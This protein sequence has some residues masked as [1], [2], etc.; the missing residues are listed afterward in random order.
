MYTVRPIEEKDNGA[1]EKVIRSCLIEY[2][3]NHEGTAWADPQLGMLS[4]AYNEEGTCY[5]VV[6]DENGDIVA[7]AGIG[8][9]AGET[10]VCEL[11]KMY[12][13]P[14]VRGKGAAS[15]LI[16]AAL[17]FAA[18]HY[19]QCYLETFDNMIP[20]QKFYEKNG[21][22]PTDRRYGD[23]GHFACDVL[24]IKNL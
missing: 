17:G 6:E 10:E 15:A 3:A 14:E 4:T 11:Q 16:D 19:K 24:Y 8:K 2:G 1:I 12:S 5:W 22:A 21:F 20:A 7:G 13:K 18:E 9:L 23:T